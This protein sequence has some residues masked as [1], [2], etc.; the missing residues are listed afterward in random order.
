[1]DKFAH[2]KSRRKDVVKDRGVNPIWLGIRKNDE[3]I[4]KSDLAQL[5]IA[6]KADIL[7]KN[8]D[9]E[10]DENLLDFMSERSRELFSQLIFSHPETQ[11]GEVVTKPNGEVV[12]NLMRYNTTFFYELRRALISYDKLHATTLKKS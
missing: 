7:S 2:E 11:L 9:D 1:M 8:P 3:Y 12:I 4:N 6:K 10:Q 5:V